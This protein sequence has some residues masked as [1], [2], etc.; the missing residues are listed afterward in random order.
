MPTREEIIEALGQLDQATFDDVINTAFQHRRDPDNCPT[1]NR[2]DPQAGPEQFARWL[3]QRHM[4]SDAAI[5]RVVYLPSGAPNNQVRLLEV[6]RFLHPTEDEAIEPLDFTPDNL[7]LPFKVFVADVT[8]GQWE[9]IKQEPMA[10]LP[11]GWRLEGNQI[12]S[13]G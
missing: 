3:A 8:R 13:R 12:Y 2:P 6:N 10:T 4:S 5:E 9:R 1:Q 11:A 7:D